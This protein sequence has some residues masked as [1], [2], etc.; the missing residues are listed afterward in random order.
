MLAA[1]GQCPNDGIVS[2]SSRDD[3]TLLSQPIVFILFGQEDVGWSI[4]KWFIPGVG[5]G[6]DFVIKI[7]LRDGALGTVSFKGRKYTRICTGVTS[8]E[9]RH[10]LVCGV[11]IVIIGYN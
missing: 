10:F 1:R 6:H 4:R 3:L 2:V 9:Q 5:Y 7:I 8:N 11:M